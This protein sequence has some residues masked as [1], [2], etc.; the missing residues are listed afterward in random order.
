MDHYLYLDETGTLDFEA[1]PGEEFFGVGTAHYPGEHAQELW[2][3]HQLRCQL[4]AGGVRLQKGLHAKNDSAATRAQVYRIVANQGA[5]FDSTLLKKANAYPRVK[6]E[7][8]VRLYKMALWLHLKHVIGLVSSPG[9]RVFVVVGHLQTST[10]RDAIR[11][12]VKDVCSQMGYDREVVACIWDAPTSWGIQVADYM[13]WR[14][15][16][17]AEGKNVPTYSDA[18]EPLIHSRFAPWGR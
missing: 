7:G 3:G 11:H 18:V 12:A 14:V 9:D 5:R 6:A 8:K 16:R 4:E 15:Q 2:Q 10:R 13:L 17:E 1:R